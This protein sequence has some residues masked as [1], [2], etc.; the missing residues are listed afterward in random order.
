V[1]TPIK[2][3]YDILFY[4][5]NNG[6]GYGNIDVVP[7]FADKARHQIKTTDK[8]SNNEMRYLTMNQHRSVRITVE[9][10]HAGN[11]SLW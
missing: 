3:V 5:K 11:D 2:C 7:G 10:V 8:K 9:T 1:W 4:I 6:V